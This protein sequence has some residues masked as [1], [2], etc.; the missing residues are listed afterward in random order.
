MR[1]LKNTH[2]S[3]PASGLRSFPIAIGITAAYRK[4]TPHS[5]GFRAPCIWMFLT[6]LRENYFYNSLLRFLLPG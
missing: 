3:R 6:S 1:L 4:S 5:S 2:L